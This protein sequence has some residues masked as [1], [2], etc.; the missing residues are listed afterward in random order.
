MLVGGDVES[1]A[2]LARSERGPRDCLEGTPLMTFAWPTALVGLGLLPLLFALYLWS[3]RRRRKYA[4]RFTNLAL[5]RE[6]VGKGPGVRRHIPP[7]LFLLGLTALLV[8]LARPS[9]VLAVPRDQASV[10]LVLDVSGSMAAHDIQPSRL[11]AAREAAKQLVHSLP[12]GAQV[13]LVAFNDRAS[14]SAPLSAD[15][16][17]VLAALDRLSAGGGTAIGDGLNLALDQLAQRP[18]DAQGDRPPGV[19]VLLSDGESNMGRPP[20]T[21]AARAQQEGVQVN[22][23]GIGT[24]GVE[25]NI[26]RQTQVGLDETTLK[27]IAGTTGGQYFYAADAGQLQQIYSHLGS[28]IMWVPEQTEVT[29]AASAL[30]AAFFTLAG[31][32]ALGWFGR[33]P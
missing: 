24:R 3:Q 6:V 16:N 13:G 27:S 18:T 22:T 28:Q 21:A 7:T 25:V 1:E 15:P 8:S 23:I 12:G 14:V 4:V 29:F 20:A 5:L 26:N 10:M 31:V 9:M 11:V 2:A 33:L 30:G 17:A 19:V 32:L